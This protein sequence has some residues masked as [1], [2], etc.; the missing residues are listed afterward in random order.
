MIMVAGAFCHIWNILVDSIIE[1]DGHAGSTL[2]FY[3]HAM[4]LIVKQ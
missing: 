1:Y 4:H 2:L 3:A